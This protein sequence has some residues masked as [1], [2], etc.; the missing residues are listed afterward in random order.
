MDL[1]RRALGAL[2]DA[3]WLR[4][5]FTADADVVHDVRHGVRMLVKSPSFTLSAVLILALGIGGTVS[6]V[7]APRHAPVQAPGLSGRRTR[8]HH[9]AA[10]GRAPRGARGCV[11]GGLPRLA[12]P[13]ALVL[14]D[15]RGD[16]V[17]HGLHGRDRAGSAFRRAG[18]R[19]LLRRR[20]DAARS[21]GRGFLP[22]EHVR[23]ARR[24]VIITYG[25][26]QSR[27]AG[28]PNIVNKSISMDERAVDDRR[29]AARSRL[30]RSS[31]RG[32]ASSPSGR[33]RSS[34]TM[35]SASAP[36]PGGTS[37]RASRRA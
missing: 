28:D 14:G 12:R 6:I 31:C 15:G 24:A 19:R 23:G 7:D 17:F 29:R 22:D 35:R 5:Q 4:R 32:R 30:R 11:A 2:P 13:G 25:F 33:R 36:V 8:R 26:W 20:R 9:L 18:H 27:Y 1:F 3:A 16:P 21:I 34:R 10:S 37:S